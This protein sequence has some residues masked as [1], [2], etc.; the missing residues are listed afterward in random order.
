MHGFPISLDSGGL[1]NN[2]IEPNGLPFV[3]LWFVSSPKLPMKS[4][5][6]YG[7]LDTPPITFDL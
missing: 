7:M 1:R 6:L 5:S 2:T 3:R 4:G